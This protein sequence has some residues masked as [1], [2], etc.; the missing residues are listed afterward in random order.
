MAGKRLQRQ[1]KSI[2]GDDAIIDR[3]RANLTALGSGPDEK[4]IEEF[5]GF[6]ENL[7]AFFSSVDMYYDQLDDRAALAQQS[8]E[9]SE[10]ELAENNVRLTHLNRLFETM[11][12]S[13]GQGFLIFDRDGFC[14]ST[15]SKACE[16]LLECDPGGLHISEV[17]RV[18]V[19][20]RETFYDWIR[21]LYEDAIDFED[22]VDVGPKLFPNT[23]Q[24]VVSLEYKPIRNVDGRLEM[25]VVIAT[26]RTAETSARKQAQKM[27]A[28]ATLMV[29]I[30]KDKDRFRRFVSAARQIFSEIYRAL[31]CEEFNYEILAEVKR[32]LHTL[33]GASCTF[34]VTQISDEIHVLENKLGDETDLR[35]VRYL[36][37]VAVPELDRIFEGLLD[38]YRD[39]LEEFLVEK[40]PARTVPIATLEDFA[41]RL[42]ELEGNEA[43]RLYMDFMEEVVT[44]PLRRI[45]AEFDMVIQQVAHKLGKE[46]E[47]IQFIGDEVSVMPESIDAFRSSL[48]HIFR[49][50]VDHGIENP[51]VRDQR[52]KPAAGRV[53]VEFRSLASSAGKFLRIII[54]DDGN[55]IDIW[56]IRIRMERSGH[57]VSGLNSQQLMGKI[58]DAGFT[59]A[60]AVSEFSGRGVGLDAV[61]IEVERLGG[62]ISVRSDLGLGSAFVIE[63]PLDESGNF[64]AP[65]KKK[66]AA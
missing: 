22:L 42:N 10:Q 1:L 38:E 8:I 13:L 54:S 55:G 52:G 15:Y 46:V 53:V 23:S 17:L 25:V 41:H 37:S 44:V 43:R 66:K 47:P 65:R 45:F 57:D 63:L 14:L 18:P 36:L 48:I 40:T 34:G 4:A 11:V 29:S 24:R 7:P 2:F 60:S 5:K 12:N 64:F 9:L 6:I 16:S 56:Q 26:D 50:I 59:T 31:N 32:N 28:F 19:D 30:L 61:K 39:I 27:Q 58:F 62:N 21:L 20:K 35:R 3:L 33:K 49:N 51:I